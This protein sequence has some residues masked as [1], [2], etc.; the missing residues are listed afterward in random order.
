MKSLK[1]VTAIESAAVRCHDASRANPSESTSSAPAL[2]AVRKSS[3]RIQPRSFEVPGLDV[4]GSR[5]R[6]DFAATK[7]A[8]AGPAAAAVE[9]TGCSVPEPGP[10][11]KSPV[12]HKRRTG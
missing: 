4:S 6:T 1:P 12:E 10:H 11:A 8:T 3:S 7:H 9:S 5:A 2:S